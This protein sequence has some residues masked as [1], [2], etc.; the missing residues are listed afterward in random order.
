MPAIQSKMTDSMRVHDIRLHE[1]QEALEL[2]KDQDP[3]ATCQVTRSGLA[4]HGHSCIG[5]AFI[6]IRN[7]SPFNA[8][9][10]QIS[11]S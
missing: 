8:S 2:S 4:F 1:I 9:D 11:H 6:Q 5:H 10:R 7:E 3:V